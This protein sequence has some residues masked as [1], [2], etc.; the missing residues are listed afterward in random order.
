MGKTKKDTNA[1]VA[2]RRK[3]ISMDNFSTGPNESNDSSISDSSESLSISLLLLLSQ[4]VTAQRY[5]MLLLTS[6]TTQH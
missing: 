5:L 2:E 3:K 6:D 1:R 4:G